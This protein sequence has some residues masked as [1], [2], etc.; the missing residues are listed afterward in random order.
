MYRRIDATAPKVTIPFS[1]NIFELERPS[2]RLVK[3]KSLH[4]TVESRIIESNW[5]DHL[6]D[7][8]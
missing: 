2:L 1:K 4:R 3:N 7:M 6:P 8:R 5:S